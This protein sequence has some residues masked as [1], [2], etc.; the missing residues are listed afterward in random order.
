MTITLQ[1]RSLSISLTV[2]DLSRSVRLYTEGL[3]FAVQQEFKMD[4]SPR[5]G[6][7]SRAPG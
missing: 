2:A 7:G 4:D 6:T 5:A 1:A 3:G